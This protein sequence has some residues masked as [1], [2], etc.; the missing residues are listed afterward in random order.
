VAEI[1]LENPE[2]PR[3]PGLG[4]CVI[5][6]EISEISGETATC[7]EEIAR[8]SPETVTRPGEI[9]TRSEETAEGSPETATRP[10]EISDGSRE[11]ADHPGKFPRRPEKFWARLGKSAAKRHSDLLAPSG[12]R[13]EVRGQ[14]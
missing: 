13:I 1:E 6:R 3:H 4:N 11:I 8:R 12:E 2:S 7:P 5:S 9:R 14:P 10:G